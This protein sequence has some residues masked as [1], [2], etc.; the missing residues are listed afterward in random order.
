MNNL[1]VRAIKYQ[2]ALNLKS[3]LRNQ[4]KINKIVEQNNSLE[5]HA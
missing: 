3:L 1:N 2:T 4:N 5:G